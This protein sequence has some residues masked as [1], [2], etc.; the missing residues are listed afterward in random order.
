MSY[1][2]QIKTRVYLA[3]GLM[4]IFALCIVSRVVWISQ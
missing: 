1:A 2:K 3:Y 4:C